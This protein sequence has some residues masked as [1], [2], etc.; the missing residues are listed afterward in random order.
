MV[1][2]WAIVTKAVFVKPLKKVLLG[3]SV[4]TLRC[5]LVFQTA[6]KN[7]CHGGV[8][9]AIVELVRRVDTHKYLKIKV[10][11][12]SLFTYAAAPFRAL[13]LLLLV[14]GL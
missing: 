10:H 8:L 7:R 9:L 11:Y 3:F 1:N 5:Y 12:G 4:S 2:H 13:L 14:V 6:G